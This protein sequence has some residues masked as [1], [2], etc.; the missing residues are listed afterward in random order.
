[1]SDFFDEFV[2]NYN[3]LAKINNKELIKNAEASEPE[4]PEDPWY[5]DYEDFEQAADE[6]YAP[7]EEKP[8]RRIGIKAAIEHL[9]KAIESLSGTGDWD[10][11]GLQKI[12]SELIWNKSKLEDL[13]SGGE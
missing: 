11:D 13:I 7:P 8:M 2:R 3:Q 9:N 12:S 6:A 1:M 10:N 4:S 5:E